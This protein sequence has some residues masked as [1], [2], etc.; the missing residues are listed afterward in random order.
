MLLEIA[1]K[2]ILIIGFGKEGRS[3]YNYF[4]RLG[5]YASLTVEAS[6]TT[7]NINFDD[8]DIVVKSP[9]V[10]MHQSPS[11]MTSL[12]ELFLSEN[13]KKTIGITGTKGKST[14]SALIDHV[15]N[16]YGKIAILVG[17]IGVPAFDR[18]DK[19]TTATNIVYE[20]SSH[21]LQFCKHSPHIAVFLNL[22]PEHLDYYNDFEEYSNAKKHVYQAQSAEDYL[23]CNSKLDVSNAKSQVIKVDESTPPKFQP[24]QLLGKHNGYNINIA[25]Q[26]A[27]LFGIDDITEALVN[28]KPLPHRLEPFADVNGV[29]YYDDSISTIPETAITAIESITD[30]STILIGGYDR[31]VDY[32]PLIKVIKSGAVE[33]VILM[34][35]TGARIYKQMG[36]PKNSANKLPKI[37]YAGM[38]SEAVA[39]ARKITPSGRSCVLSP[40][41]A[42]YNEF[43]NFE[44]RGDMF[45]K[46]VLGKNE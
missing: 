26:V 23:I 14:V 46:L 3:V 28:F 39:L 37:Y 44:E 6:A 9:G 33:N 45:K 30:L 1:N 4:R 8:F 19:I 18:I 12:T 29:L 13:R 16:F 40:A 38:L 15:L 35:D 17:N 25:A 21:Q 27:K 10:P 41:S 32:T 43:K 20:M 34:S 11:N 42:S 2:R 31:G 7:D 22:Y 36:S 5:G 24:P